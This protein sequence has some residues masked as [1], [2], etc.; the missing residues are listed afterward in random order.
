MEAVREPVHL[1]EI[2]QELAGPDRMQAM[3]KYDAILLGLEN[4]IADALRE[5]LPSDDFQNVTLLRE[6]NVTARKILR[7]TV[8]VDG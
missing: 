6:A 3:E 4:R 1:L 5:G 8:R 2:E 7:L